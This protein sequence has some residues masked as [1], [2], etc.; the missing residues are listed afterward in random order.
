MVLL[1]EEEARKE[2]DFLKQRY[3]TVIP[4]LGMYDQTLSSAPTTEPEYNLDD[5]IPGS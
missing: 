2:L 3:G 5:V 1:S 4:Q